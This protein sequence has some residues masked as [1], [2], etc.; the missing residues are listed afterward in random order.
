VIDLI[1][2]KK[3][4]AEATKSYGE[5]ENLVSLPGIEPRLFGRPARNL[6]AI[7]TE[8]SRHGKKKYFAG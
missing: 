8:L 3:R 6:V 4:Y 5:G 1:L 2:R 7:P